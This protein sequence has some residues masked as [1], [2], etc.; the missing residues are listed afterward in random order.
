[1]AIKL[2]CDCGKALSVKDEAAGKRVKCPG[3]QTLLRVPKPKV[4]EASFGE[5]W[6]LGDA[7]EEDFDDE[8][9]HTRAKSRGGRSSSNR[10]S[11]SR[12]N[13]TKFKGK[14]SQRSNRGLLMGLS[15]GGGLLVVALLAWM[16]W[17]ASK[18]PNVVAPANQ[19]AT[20]APT[21]TGSEAAS[22]T[23]TASR[24]SSAQPIAGPVNSLPP[25]AT[26][27]LEG[28]L[29]LMQGSWQVTKLE[30]P[31]EAPAAA[32]ALTRMKQLTFSIKDDILTINTPGGA[33][34]QTIKLDSL[35]TP[36]TIDLTPLETDRQNRPQIG[37]YSIEGDTWQMCSTPGGTERPQEMKVAP[38]QMVATFQR[39]TAPATDQALLFNLKAWIA[40]ESKFKALK[41]EAR[42]SPWERYSDT[43]ALTHCLAVYPPETTDGTMSPELWAI[44]SSISHVVV[45]TTFSTDDTLRQLAQHPGLMGI[46]MDRRSTVTAAGIKALAVCPRLQMLGFHVPVSPEVCETLPQL[47]QLRGLNIN[48]NPVSKEML[49]S[50]ARIK[51][52]KQLSLYNAGTTDDDAR[53]IQKLTTLESLNLGNSQLTDEGLKAL[54]S[55][56]QLESLFLDQAKV[57]DQGLKTLQGFTGLK[58]LSL[59]G[60]NVTPQAIA[61][62]EAALPKCR[63]LK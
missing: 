19:V 51:R 18:G 27:K 47:E 6:E 28:D 46:N 13:S 57:S 10:G 49:S 25:V 1:M 22:S 41:V 55:L 4:E 56:T 45:I 33:S 42:L 36:K 15:A 38:G 30:M 35:Q 58:M 17:P 53:Q 8:P 24:E 11:N 20:G 39:S 14:K 5:E 54:A 34:F 63:V 50:I 2:K 9:T 29:N 43:E 21:A 60:L 48:N 61:E 40:A 26:T 62:L 44:V 3:C 52:L 16:F 59:R 31:P 32:E 12:Q 37:I 23:H 7:S